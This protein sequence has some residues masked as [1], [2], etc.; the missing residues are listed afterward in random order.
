M[1]N[2]SSLVERSLD[3]AAGT[4]VDIQAYDN[5]GINLAKLQS[6]G[7]CYRDGWLH[8]VLCRITPLTARQLDD[9]SMMA[10]LFVQSADEAEE[11]LTRMSADLSA[12]ATAA[13]VHPTNNSAA[14]IRNHLALYEAVSILLAQKFEIDIPAPFGSTTINAAMQSQ[15]PFVRQ[16]ISKHFKVA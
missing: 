12:F 16:F 8:N 2:Y 11:L 13:G 9:Y 3:L 5:W 4:R 1:H 15:M 10:D 6:L 7:R 14:P